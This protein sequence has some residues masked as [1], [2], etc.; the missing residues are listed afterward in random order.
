L[1]IGKLTRKYWRTE[2]K[3]K[4]NIRT[5]LCHTAKRSKT[6]IRIKI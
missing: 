5:F 1:F 4:C 3:A 2:V 6:T